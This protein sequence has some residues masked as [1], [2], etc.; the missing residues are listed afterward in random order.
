MTTRKN[1]RVGKNTRDKIIKDEKSF[2]TREDLI[3][4]L[5]Y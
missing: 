4:D 5:D 2:Y 1:A 3:D